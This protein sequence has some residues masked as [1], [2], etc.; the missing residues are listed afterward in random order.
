MPQ[1]SHLHAGVEPRNGYLPPRHILPRL[2]AG[3][4][5]AWAAVPP[6]AALTDLAGERLAGERLAERAII[7]LAHEVECLYLDA[8]ISDAAV[9]V[10]SELAPDSPHFWTQD[11]IELRFLRDPARDLD[12]IQFIVAPDGRF[13][14]NQGLWRQGAVTCV[15]LHDMQP[16][17]PTADA[18][19]GVTQS[20]QAA[21]GW[22]VRLS[23]PYAALGLRAPQAGE[24][25]RGIVAH[26]RWGDGFADFACSAA[27]ELG[28][29]QAERFGEWRFAECAAPI[30]LARVAPGRSGTQTVTL[31]NL[32]DQRVT[33]ELR[34]AGDVSAGAAGITEAVPCRLRPGANRVAVKLPLTHPQFRRWQLSF[35]C[36]GVAAV[37]LGGV[38]L[39]AP[40]PALAV[41]RRGLHHPCLFFDAA[42]LDALRAKARLAPFAEA[43]AEVVPSELDVTG[44]DLPGPDDTVSMAIT[45]DCMN[46]F[47]V[48]RET[49]LRDG[50]GNC[51]P[52]ARHLWSLQSAAAQQAWRELV[53][54]VTP[55][56]PQLAILIPELNG[57][58]ARGD[59]YN[60]VAFADVALPEEG[61]QLLA[62][63][64]PALSAAELFRL[65]RIVMQ[66]GV[67]C[68]GNFRMDLVTRP[69]GL[70]E[71]WL[72][73]GDSRLIAT[74][75]KAV[76]AALRLTI[77]EHQIHLHEGMAAGSLA[78]AY[79]AFY[80]RL[81]PAERRDWQALLLR[82]LQL[83]LE[84]ARHRSWTVT[85]IANANPVGNGGCGLAALALYREHPG[86]CREALD[87][88]RRNIRLW[89]DYCHGADGGNT[90]GAQYWQYGMD[91]CLRFAVALE[92]VAGCSLLEH[93]AVRQAMNMVRVG[94]SNDGA[95]H[96]VNDTV[97]MPVGGAIAWFLA[98]RFGDPLG[99]GYGDHAWRWL[100][101]RRAAGKPLA[102]GA[103]VVEMLLYR[104]A[105][106]ECN[107]LPPVP[108]VLALHSIECAVVRSGPEFNCRWVA[109]VKG[110]R[111]PYTH[112]NQ[113][114]TGSFYIDL[115]GERLLIDPGYYKPAPTDHC[116]PLIGGRGPAPPVAWTGAICGAEERGD[117]RYLACDATAAYAG[118]A[119]RVVRH[120][121]LLGEEG[122]VL[123]DDVVAAAPVTAQYQCGGPTAALAAG[124]AVVIAGDQ[125]RLRLELLTHPE[126][127]PVLKPERSLRDTHWGYHF[128]D[129]RLFPV[130]VE[131][132][133]VEREPLVAVFVDVTA[134][135]PSPS[136]VIHVSGRLTVELP[137]GRQVVFV[138][139]AAGWE[140]V[141]PDVSA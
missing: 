94:L 95:L 9:T 42:G 86:V 138:R 141:W 47:R 82:F 73:T 20:T 117:L 68:M 21:P 112:H 92:R 74:A 80:S 51:R 116:L 77:L 105:V 93:S 66:S 128:A 87:H 45:R 55:T 30:C 56:E 120:L 23:I 12:Q 109:G 118:A 132:A 122:G 99:L 140:L 102:Y 31:M 89:L 54:S 107:V 100:Q 26:T 57:L 106:P 49:M 8:Q 34:I 134:G 14:D 126:A 90:E 58:L 124:R 10:K 67:E 60:P 17:T 81:S 48:G 7:R 43:A 63:G 33:G 97:P 50:E 131:Y 119:T 29:P 84:T 11:H 2:P 53:K 69:G 22:H 135:E 5:A 136:R 46:W 76:R 72:V 130:T 61:R 104:P 38:T 108:T 3:G 111:P 40:Q 83:Y 91:N 88:A 129:C 44:A 13:W 52:A 101:A 1:L 37:D 110:S 98:G 62:R 114:D 24:C 32:T 75:T 6:V 15:A 123:V 35:S 115:R 18:G 96:G 41:A 64:I 137:S 70:W 85:T 103:G 36:L 133:A 127:T 25:W 71:K 19:A 79:D 28:F 39:R 4:D 16:P 139:G 78:Q 65:N 125:A 59:F 113:A 121:V 27:T